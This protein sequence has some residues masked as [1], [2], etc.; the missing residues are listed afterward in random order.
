MTKKKLQQLW[1]YG[2]NIK[3]HIL[4]N[5]RMNI[6][7]GSIGMGKSA[8]TFLLA[9]LKHNHT[10]KNPV[11]VH[12]FEEEK[13]EK[14]RS[15]L[16]KWIKLSTQDNIIKGRIDY[17]SFP[18]GSI[19]IIEELAGVDSSKNLPKD[20][21]AK[22][23]I[24]DM[25][26]VRHRNQFVFGNI[27]NTALLNKDHFRGG[28]HLHFKAMDSLA[29]CFERQ[30]LA[31]Y[32]NTINNHVARIS[33]QYTVDLRSLVYISDLAGDGVFKET[34]PSFWTNELSNIWGDNHTS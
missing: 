20:E 15:L 22:R 5:P 33:N 7:I 23:L 3:E 21:L 31:D 12:V 27:Q 4:N 14:L 16:P 19:I 29:I 30:E 13:R 34:L 9:E 10:P 32:F 11:F 6:I 17:R 1:N 24:Y 26:T 2:Q 8:H 18:H 28:T 25:M